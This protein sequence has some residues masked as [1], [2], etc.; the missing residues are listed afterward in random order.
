M[1]EEKLTVSRDWLFVTPIRNLAI[2][3]DL[4]N[5]VVI[6]RVEY[7]GSDRLP[8]V[9]RRIGITHRI[10]QLR[11]SHDG[12][13]FDSMLKENST[14]ALLPIKLKHGQDF[15]GVTNSCYAIIKDATAILSLSRCL[16]SRRRARDIFGIGTQSACAWQNYA[17]LKRGDWP[18]KRTPQAFLGGQLEGAFGPF[19]IDKNWWN[20][21]NKYGF[22]FALLDILYGRK[23]QGVSRGWRKRLENAA[24]FAGRSWQT[25]DIL[26]AFLYNVFALETLLLGDGGRTEDL[27]KRIEIFLGWAGFWGHDK[28]FID[29]VEEMHKVRHNIVHKADPSGLS[30]DH[31]L[32]SD[33]LV[34][35]L[36]LNLVKHYRIFKQQKDVTTFCQKIEAERILGLK[37]IVRPRTF[38]AMAPRY[39]DKDRAEI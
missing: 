39:S 4:R 7:I 6:G 20:W 11:R 30:L 24:L 2:G 8:Y 3:K 19:V 26:E 36:L 34:F 1:E 17:F 9:R 37:H 18:S 29:K 10:S 31:L 38:R 15:E 5:R 35:N 32:F 25:R 22:F 14:L 16:Y 21:H 33:D 12:L 28:D 13:S 23:K 27:A